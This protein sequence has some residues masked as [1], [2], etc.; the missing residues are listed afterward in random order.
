MQKGLGN[1]ICRKPK[2]FKKR[3]KKERKEERKK[4]RKKEKKKERVAPLK[5]SCSEKVA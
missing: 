2:V 5:V 3:K 4:R 1:L